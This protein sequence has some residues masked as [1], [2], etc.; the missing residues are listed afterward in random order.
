VEATPAED[1]RRVADSF[2]EVSDEARFADAGRP[3]QRE[4]PARPV[5][6]GILEVT[7]EAF[8]LAP[9]AD[10]RRVEPTRDRLR[11]GDHVEQAERL[12]R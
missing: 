3:E 12:D 1:V 5:G 10:Q 9:A 2:E 7:A 8:A 11:V 6:D 4:E